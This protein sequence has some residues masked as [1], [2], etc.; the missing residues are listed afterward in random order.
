MGTRAGSTLTGCGDSST[1]SGAESGLPL[2][3]PLILAKVPLE[4]FDDGLAV[5]HL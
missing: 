4:L 2:Q 5:P 3:Q 1:F